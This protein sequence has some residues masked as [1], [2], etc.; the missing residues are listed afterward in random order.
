M[1]SVRPL[2]AA[3]PAALL[4]VM[5]NTLKLVKAASCAGESNLNHVAAD[6][7]A[8][9]EGACLGSPAPQVLS[10]PVRTGNRGSWFCR[11]AGC[12]M[13]GVWWRSGS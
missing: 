2:G 12:D 11:S 7:A 13:A 4:P 10:L 6:L 9:T 1:A 8:V 3:C 5:G